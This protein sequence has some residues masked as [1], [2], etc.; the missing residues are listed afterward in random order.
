MI[1]ELDKVGE[2]SLV[3]WSHEDSSKKEFIICSGFDDSKPEGSK[4][5][6]GHYYQNLDD[7]YKY[8]KEKQKE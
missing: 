4:W 3:V 7:A 8:W 6:W 5:Y 1:V 2:L